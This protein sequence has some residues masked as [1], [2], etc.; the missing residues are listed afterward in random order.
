[1]ATECSIHTLLSFLVATCF[2]VPTACSLVFTTID[3]IKSKYIYAIG[4]MMM[5]C[6]TSYHLLANI[7]LSF[8]MVIE[9]S[10]K[11]SNIER[12]SRML[13]FISYGQ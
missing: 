9:S 6:V 1:M 3:F 11:C 8:Q 7:P 10:Q 13:S 4:I 2:R 12:P 5:E